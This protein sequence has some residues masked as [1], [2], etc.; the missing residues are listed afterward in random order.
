[1]KIHYQC[2][3]IHIACLLPISI[4]LFQT[5][6]EYAFKTYRILNFSPS[7]RRNRI[8]A[9]GLINKNNILTP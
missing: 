6:N 5:G 4:N 1:M 9:T 8:S 2:K 3:S 7:R